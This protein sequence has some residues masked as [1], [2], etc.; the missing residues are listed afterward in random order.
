[1]VSLGSKRIHIALTDS[2]GFGVHEHI[3][4]LN[5][6]GEYFD[7]KPY[8]GATFRDLVGDAERYLKNHLFDVV[9]IAGGANDITEKNKHTK[10][11]SF[12]WG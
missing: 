12:N 4:R 1:M 9:Y 6:T 10:A 5:N 8:N 3:T 11:I 2:R 7:L